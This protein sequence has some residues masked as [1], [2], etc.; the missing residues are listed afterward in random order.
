MGGDEKKTVN[1]QNQD[2]V[3]MYKLHDN[4]YASNVTPSL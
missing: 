1:T 3:Y 4:D 2:D